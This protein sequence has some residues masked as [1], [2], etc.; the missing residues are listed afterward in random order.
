MRS[1][2]RALLTAGNTDAKLRSQGARCGGP[3]IF[4]RWRGLGRGVARLDRGCQN[5]PSHRVNISQAH[6]VLGLDASMVSE[7]GND[8]I[9]EASCRNGAIATQSIGPM[10]TRRTGCV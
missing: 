8:R 10:Q 6:R 5:R 2:V 7:L 3:E 1:A 4:W 9:E